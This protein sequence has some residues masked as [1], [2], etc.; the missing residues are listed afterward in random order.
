MQFDE[1]QR[2][3][4]EILCF[5]DRA[6]SQ[7]MRVKKPTWCTI[8]LQFIQSLYFYRFRVASSPSLEG[9]N[10]YMQQALR[11]VR[12]SRLS[13]G[14]TADSWYNMYN[15]YQLLHIYIVTS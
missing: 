10:V 1:Y 6:A 9:N 12:F 7:Y 8:Y 15:M 11:V 13:A 5:I 3:G 4:E 14:G 2:F